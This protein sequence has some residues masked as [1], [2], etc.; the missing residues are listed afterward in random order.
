MAG[1]LGIDFPRQIDIVAVEVVDPYTVGGK[2]TPP[3][4]SALE[5]VIFGVRKALGLSN[6]YNEEVE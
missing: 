4:A 6:E 2:M 5:K 3:V 1:M